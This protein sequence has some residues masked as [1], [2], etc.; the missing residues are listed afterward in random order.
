M[1][2]SQRKPKSIERFRV[3]KG[4]PAVKA[5][6]YRLLNKQYLDIRIF[7]GYKEIKDCNPGHRHETVFG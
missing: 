5:F 7:R 6:M 4:N 3:G 2:A 1:F